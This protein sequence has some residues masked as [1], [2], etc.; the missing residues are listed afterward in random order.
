MILDFIGAFLVCGGI[1]FLSQL[2]ID[3]SKLTPGHVTSLFVVIGA[4][5]EFF[6]LYD[7][8]RQF[9]KMGA[10]L[11]ICSFGSV[12]MKGVK[13]GVL[14]N[15]FMGIF[16]GVFENCGGLIALAV[17]LAFVSTLFFKPKA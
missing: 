13:N 1:C 9:G 11:P 3:H 14:E 10:A 7:Y 2:I 4:V 12:M 6:N 15:G 16:K 17:F 8:L 5:L